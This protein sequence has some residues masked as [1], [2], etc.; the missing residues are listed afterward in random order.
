MQ[1]KRRAAAH[2]MRRRALLLVATGIAVLG[3]L[4]LVFTAG[5]IDEAGLFIRGK[6]TRLLGTGAATIATVDPETT[7]TIVGPEGANIT[8]NA[9]IEA[10]GR[11][12]VRGDKLELYTSRFDDGR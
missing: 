3:I 7:V 10:R 12:R 6:V 4:L 11:A 9:I 1:M 8:V 5:I 2:S